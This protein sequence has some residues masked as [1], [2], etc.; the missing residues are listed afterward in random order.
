MSL[1]P[2]SLA[3]FGA[4]V[5]ADGMN[6]YIAGSAGRGDTNKENKAAFDDWKIVSPPVPACLHATSAEGD[7]ADY[8]VMEIDSQSLD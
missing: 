6:R 3:L 8:D 2:P 4:Y 5:D 1:S 7:G